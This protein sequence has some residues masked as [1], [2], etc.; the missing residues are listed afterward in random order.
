MNETITREQVYEAL[1]DLPQHN[2]LDEA[3]ERLVFLAGLKEGLEQAE[4]GE[5]IPHE[6]VKK[7]I[8]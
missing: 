5:G 3:I 1:R 7:M 8:D 6:D 4:R 2:A